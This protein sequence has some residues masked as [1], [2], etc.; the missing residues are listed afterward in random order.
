MSS[1]PASRDGRMG[2]MVEIVTWQRNRPETEVT[3]LLARGNLEIVQVDLSRHSPGVG[4]RIGDVRLAEEAHIVTVIR[5]ERGLLPG[6]T[7][8]FRPAIPS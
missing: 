6:P 7:P 5:S 2:W 8:F 4:Q 1:G 3:R